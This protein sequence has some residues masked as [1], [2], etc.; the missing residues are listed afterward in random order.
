ME[1]L[2]RSCLEVT[3]PLSVVWFE[4]HTWQ[5]RNFIGSVLSAR[6]ELQ[7]GQ[8]TQKQPPSEHHVSEL[9][10]DPNPTLS[11]HFS[12]TLMNQRLL[13]SHFLRKLKQKCHMTASGGHV[14]SGPTLQDFSEN[15]FQLFLWWSEQTPSGK[16]YTTTTTVASGASEELEPWR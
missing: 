11:N 8:Q 12:T 16:T 6:A 9:T 5:V 4:R 3:R 14:T 2:S 7:H 13:C 15:P 1:K 10:S